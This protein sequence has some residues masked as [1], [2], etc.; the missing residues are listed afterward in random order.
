MDITTSGPTVEVIVD[1]EPF[2]L[3]PDDAE[4][5]ESL[6]T[7]TDRIREAAA[8]GDSKALRAMADEMASV[9][10]DALGEGATR[11]L[12]RGKRPVI[13]MARLIVSLAEAVGASLQEA[14]AE[15]LD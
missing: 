3:C 14:F 8:E 9:I 12:F 1:G 6:L 2:E 5:I 10:D 15:Y 11:K 4:L 7:W 13:R